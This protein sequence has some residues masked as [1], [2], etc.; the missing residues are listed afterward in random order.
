MRHLSTGMH[1]IVRLHT[2]DSVIDSLEQVLREGLV[3]NA[4]VHFGI[5]SLAEAE[6]GTLPASGHHARHK[7]KGPAE[8]VYLSGLI[9]GSGS[10]GPYD[11]HLHIA[12]ADLE[13]TVRGGHLFGA[14]VG[15]MVEVGMTPI[16]DGRMKRVR[17]EKRGV[18]LL[19][20]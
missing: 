2:G 4:M 5:G 12:V 16:H 9:V 18:A 15:A 19:E 13:G 8:L 10:G 14:T 17:D 6:F 1:T 7:V 3:R 11:P 20:F